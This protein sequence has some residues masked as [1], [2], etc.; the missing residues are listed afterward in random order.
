VALEA[1][2][3]LVFSY[4]LSTGA[5]IGVT[6]GFTVLVVVLWYGLPLAGRE[7]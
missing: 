1:V 5:A 2:V 3:L 7:R 4:V 6:V